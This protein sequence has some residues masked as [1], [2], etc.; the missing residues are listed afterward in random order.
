MFKV[1]I[2]NWVQG[3]VKKMW[4]ITWLEK[5]MNLPWVNCWSCTTVGDSCMNMETSIRYTIGG[6]SKAQCICYHFWKKKGSEY[7]YIYVLCEKTFLEGSQ[8]TGEGTWVARVRD[9]GQRHGPRGG[10]SLQ[11]LENGDLEPWESR[12]K[13]WIRYLRGGS[14][15]VLLVSR[16]EDGGRHG[17]LVRRE[18]QVVGTRKGIWG[19]SGFQLAALGHQGAVKLAPGSGQGGA[20]EA[21][22]PPPGP[23]PGRSSCLWSPAPFPRPFPDL[24]LQPRGAP[25][26][27]PP[28]SSWGSAWWRG[29][30]CLPPQLPVFVR[31]S[32]SILTTIAWDGYCYLTHFIDGKARA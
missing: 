27:A 12:G 21:G 29:H 28:S 4:N 1:G 10:G 9:G 13:L 6:K 3:L 26:G 17:K 32:Y 24:R 22:P 8:E 15:D 23:P 20:P 11:A 18:T 7:I 14:V 16:T 2:L 25:C 30:W 19:W 31:L 5:R